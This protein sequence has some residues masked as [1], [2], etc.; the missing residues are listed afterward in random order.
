MLTDVVYDSLRDKILNLE[1]KPGTPLSFST[2]SSQYKVSISPIRDALKRL[3]T[4]GL[5]EI[6]PQSGTYV[7]LIDLD[8]VRDER[9][10]RLYLELGVIEKL[11][12]VGISDCLIEKWEELLRLQEEAF[13]CRNTAKFLDLDDQMHRLLFAECKHEKVFTL[14]KN[15]GGNYHRIR[16]VSY[17][18]D[19]ILKNILVQHKELF[20]ALKKRDI[21]E[22]LR[23]D[24][25]HISK[26]E[27]ETAEYQKAY[28]QYFRQ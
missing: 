19:D 16:M 9:F 14:I 6:K 22:L 25:Q 17:L 2:L 1:L 27:V 20:E 28:P 15:T 12:T 7:S 3:D 8:K 4:E 18:F 11:Q 26:I 24:R 13:S 10:M 21:Q 23:V 5:V